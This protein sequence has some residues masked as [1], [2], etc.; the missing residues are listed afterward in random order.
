MT[1]LKKI[2]RE[3]PGRYECFNLGLIGI[4]IVLRLNHYLSNRA[5]WMDECWRAMDIL[6]RSFSEIVLGQKLTVPSPLGFSVL[7]KISVMLLGNHEYSFRFLSI[8][9]GI[10]SLFI[11]YQLAKKILVARAVPLALGLF[12]FC[13]SFIYFSGE[14]KQYSTDVLMSLS[15]LFLAVR[16]LS[17]IKTSRDIFLFAAVGML[18]AWVSYPALFVLLS[19]ACVFIYSAL[20]R[21]DFADLRRQAAVY[22]GWACMVLVVYVLAISKRGDIKG[23]ASMWSSSFLP[24]P[25][26]SKASLCWLGD[27]LLSVFENPVGLRFPL[28]GLGLFSLGLVHLSKRKPREAFLLVMPL[29]IP[30]ILS[31]LRLYPFSGRALIF[32]CPGM[33]L[34]ICEGV[35]FLMQRGRT[36]MALGI[37]IYGLML[38][39]PV[40]N[41]VGHFPDPYVKEDIRPLMKYLAEHSQADDGLILS[42]G[43]LYAFQYYQLRFPVAAKVMAM[44]SDHLREENG[45]PFLFVYHS[46]CQFD[47]RIYADGTLA[48]G[49]ITPEKHHLETFP[50]LPRTWILLSHYHPPVN[51]FLA[52]YLDKT[53]ERLFQLKHGEPVLFLYAFPSSGKGASQ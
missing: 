1:F 35:S 14:A 38:V 4:G 2:F 15:V 16:L 7:S 44:T 51:E 33:I 42:G 47:S 5:L 8:S 26:F 39:Y 10:L 21:R 11:F 46:P 23:L 34:F 45:R 9:A 27:R 18:A 24:G 50:V 48:P 29:F 37:V 28:V 41:A 43:T 30:L 22:T 36:G 52:S 6:Q 20:V 19:T 32:I 3:P 53:G 13:D 17:G 25:I 31:V 12:V 40:K 49:N